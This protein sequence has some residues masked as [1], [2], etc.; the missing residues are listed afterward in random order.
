[1]LGAMETPLT[2]REYMALCIL[3]TLISGE[4]NRVQVAST[5]THDQAKDRGLKLNRTLESL[6]VESADR[7]IV[8]LGIAAGPTREY[9][10]GVTPNVKPIHAEFDAVPWF[11]PTWILAP[12]GEVT[13]WKDA[14]GKY[15][16]PSYPTPAAADKPKLCYVLKSASKEL[17]GRPLMTRFTFKEAVDIFAGKMGCT[18]DAAEVCVRG[19][20][21][22]GVKDWVF[23]DGCTM[24][25]W[26]IDGA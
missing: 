20:E 12:E 6:A 4:V 22:H 25:C 3:Q 11:G 17:N 10:A 14:D 19:L 16:K 26:R 5:M 9:V 15:M 18:K 7:L 1:M 24:R 13:P 2:K 21:A 23:A 8:C